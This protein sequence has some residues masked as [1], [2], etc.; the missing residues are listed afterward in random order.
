VSSTENGG[1]HEEG[2]HG[3]L[4]RG[5]RTGIGEGGL[6]MCEDVRRRSAR[7]IGRQL[8][9]WAPRRQRRADFALAQVEPFPEALPGP[10]TSPVVGDRADRRGNGAGDGVF[11][12]SPQRAGCQAQ[13]SDFVGAPDA[14]R[15]PASRAPIAVAAKDPP[16]AD[17]FALGIALIE[18]AQIAVA[19]QR[20]NRFAMRTRRLLEPFGNRVPFLLTAVKP[21]LLAHVSP[22]APQKSPSYA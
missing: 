19:N 22:D 17:R 10:V 21:R 20:A 2:P 6:E 8:G 12:E 15:P 3:L 13:P 16:R 9:R 4:E 14:E 18:T 5:D 1:L 7:R 11:E